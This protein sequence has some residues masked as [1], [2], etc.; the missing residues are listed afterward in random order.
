MEEEQKQDETNEEVG[1]TA[2]GDTGLASALN[3][4][5][6]PADEEFD[7]Q[8]ETNTGVIYTADSPEV[9]KYKEIYPDVND[10][11]AIGSVIGMHQAIVEGSEIAGAEEVAEVIEMIKAKIAE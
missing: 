7:Q 8:G 1:N 10:D 3:A 6:P 2:T 4:D 9:I 11:A 5:T